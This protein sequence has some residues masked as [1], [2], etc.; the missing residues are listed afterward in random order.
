ML[1]GVSSGSIKELLRRS[2]CDPLGSP[3]RLLGNCSGALGGLAGSWG[4]LEAS[5][6]G[7]P[8]GPRDGLTWPKQCIIFTCLK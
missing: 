5:W 7:L 3:W 1:L 8:K 2:T 6:A 4:P